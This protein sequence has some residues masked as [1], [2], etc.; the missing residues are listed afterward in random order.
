M[1]RNA[2]RALNLLDTASLAAD[3]SVGQSSSVGNVLE[4]LDSIESLTLV[5]SNVERPNGLVWRIELSRNSTGD[6]WTGCE[7]ID[8]LTQ[9]NDDLFNRFGGD[10]LFVFDFGR[11]RH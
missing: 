8:G 9:G 4:R 6:C 10:D 11:R 5:G 3:D 2:A 1:A 7:V